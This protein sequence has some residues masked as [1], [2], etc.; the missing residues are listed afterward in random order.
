M[1]SQ[2]KKEALTKLEK[3]PHQ[4]KK[5]LAWLIFELLMTIMAVSA[6]N[7]QPKLGWPLASFMVG[8]V[9]MMGAATMYF[10]GKQA[11]LDTAVRG[12]AMIGRAPK[13]LKDMFDKGE[14]D[15]TGG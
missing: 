12:F 3:K 7:N 5:F 9:F 13:N 10:L 15:G 1:T 6:I 14:D 11:A 2:E 4:S 8:I